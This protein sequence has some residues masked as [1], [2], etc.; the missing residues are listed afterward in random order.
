MSTLA[1][2]QEYQLPVAGQPYLVLR[3]TV[4]RVG[5]LVCNANSSGIVYM[6]WGAPNTSA[7]VPLYP[8]EKRLM[9]VVTP[10]DALYMYGQNANALVII[11]ECTK[12]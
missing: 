9:D 8:N 5:L 10:T 2:Q 6:V 3:S 12:Q 4:N 7:G 1:N 11:E